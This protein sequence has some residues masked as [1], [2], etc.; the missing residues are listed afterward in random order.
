MNLNPISSHF[1][2]T[3]SEKR[4]ELWHIIQSTHKAQDRG[5][6]HQTNHINR[7]IPIPGRLGSRFYLQL[8][9]AVGL[10]GLPRDY[11]RINVQLK[12]VC[13]CAACFWPVNVSPGG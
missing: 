5:I 1:H 4:K 13:H 7:P 3:G 11:T 6:A 8:N 2:A 12:C 9:D 10:A